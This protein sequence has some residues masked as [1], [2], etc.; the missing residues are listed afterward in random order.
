MKTLEDVKFFEVE[1]INWGHMTKVEACQDTC[2][3]LIIR[4]EDGKSIF[5]QREDDID[6]I[7]DSMVYVEET[8]SYYIYDEYYDIAE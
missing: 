8:N 1:P 2:G 6:S 4:F 5:A 3:S 7:I